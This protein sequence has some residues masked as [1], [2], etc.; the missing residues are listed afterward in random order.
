[1]VPTRLL[2]LLLLVTAAIYG[3]VTLDID[4]TSGEEPIKNII[5]FYGPSETHK[6]NEQLQD[7]NPRYVTYYTVGPGYADKIRGFGYELVPSLSQRDSAG[8]YDI[9][10]KGKASGVEH[11]VLWTEPN[12]TWPDW[13][14][15]NNWLKDTTWESFISHAAKV[16]RGAREADPECLISAPCI[17]TDPKDEQWFNHVR[18]FLDS[19]RAWDM[20]VDYVNVHPPWE[21]NDVISISGLARAYANAAPEMGIKGIS[22]G[23]Y[24]YFVDENARHVRFFAA[25]ETA[26]NCEF[27]C[28]SSY[29]NMGANSGLSTKKDVLKPV[30]W[31][32]WYYS[33]MT[34]RRLDLA[35]GE[36]AKLQ[37]LVALSSY[38]QEEKKLY[39]LLGNDA[40]LDTSVV[41]SIGPAEGKATVRVEGFE[42]EGL[43]LVREDEFTAAN[44]TITIDLGL[45]PG[46]DARAVTIVF[47]EDPMTAVRNCPSLRISNRGKSP[48]PAEVYSIMGRRVQSSI[49][50]APRIE[51]TPEGTILRISPESRR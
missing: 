32:Y 1:M 7:L 23:E 21:P 29:W 33:R 20:K 38:D 39:M 16:M 42:P 6:T 2:G 24:P 18:Q 8:A 5:D 34:G 45:I 19:M 12:R 48:G 46:K 13:G 15:A 40:G 10:S 17:T 9:V 11:Y 37:N 27:A 4:V 36:T 28:K 31:V 51:A 25:F 26:W 49:E 3:E 47:D 22:V 30:Y 35:I 14:G 50:R 41:L 44:G 43:A